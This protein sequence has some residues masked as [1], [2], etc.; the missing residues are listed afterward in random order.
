LVDRHW[1]PLWNKTFGGYKSSR[2]AE[3]T[4]LQM[5]ILLVHNSYQQ[6]G[7]ED[8]VFEQERRLLELN[9]NI[10]ITYRRSNWEVTAYSGLRRLK[11]VGRTIWARDARQQLA[12]LLDQEKPDLV[13]VHNT[14]VMVS[15]SIF[16]ACRDADVPVVQTLHNYRLYCPAGTFFRDG[17]ICEECIEHGLWRGVAHACYRDSRAATTVVATMLAVHRQRQ[18]WNREVDCY[19]A[20]S[21]FS[22]A[23]FLECGLPAEKVFVKPNFVHPDPGPNPY[24]E[25]E[26]ALFVGRLSPEKRVSTV[27]AAWYHLRKL[28]IPLVILGGGPQLGQMQKEAFRQGLTSVSF[29]G[30]VSRDETLAMMRKARF[31][32][33]SSEW[34]ENFPVTIAE[35]FACGVPVICS[36]IG[37]MQEIVEDGRTGLH[38]TPGNAADLSEKVEWAWNHPEAMASMGNEARHEYETKYTAT[39][40]YPLLMEIYQHALRRRHQICEMSR[41]PLT[42]SVPDQM[43]H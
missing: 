43:P 31:L 36:R 27:L 20:L 11:L 1:N 35:S 21:E 32:V 14:L 6:P 19:I 28:N 38:F 29:R 5:K 15:P 23:K 39:K 25:G 16:S 26:Y 2:A 41:G 22:R 8:V 13:H 10:V 37:A 30:R 7:G 33:F 40:N 4:S 18:T 9:G 42:A 24:G 3:R 17:H 34:Y 12:E